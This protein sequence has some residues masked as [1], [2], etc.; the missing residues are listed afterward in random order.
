M[1]ISRM[2]VSGRDAVHQVVD[3]VHARAG[4][5]SSI[6]S[7]DPLPPPPLAPRLCTIACSRA[8]TK[9]LFDVL[10][11]MAKREQMEQD[12]LQPGKCGPP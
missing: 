12:S 8:T 6:A 11:F 10:Q 9:Q 7:A 3:K 4:V 1:Q 2:I 5:R